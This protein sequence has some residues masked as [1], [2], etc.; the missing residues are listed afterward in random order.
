MALVAHAFQP[1][2][3]GPEVDAAFA[4]EHV[5]LLV[6]QVV[7]DADLAHALD[8]ERIQETVNPFGHQGRVVDGE[9]PMQIGRR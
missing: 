1:G 5:V 6:A 7:G 3:Q 2:E 8:A 4:G 9:R